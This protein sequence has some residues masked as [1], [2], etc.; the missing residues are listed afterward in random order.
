MT[1][2]DI[3]KAADFNLRELIAAEAD[4]AGP[5]EA[6]IAAKV[7]PMIPE[8]ERDSV[9]VMLLARFIAAERP[10]L[11]QILA[12]APRP[13]VR[14]QRSTK[15]AA[16][17]AHARFL[18]LTVA[19]GRSEIKWMA[20]CTYEDLCYA[21]Q[22]R[23]QKAAETIAAAEQYEVLAALV[24]EHRVARVSDLP[25]PVLQEFLRDEKAAA[26]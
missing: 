8:A 18:R 23:R 14:S 22:N 2:F 16:Y 21:A 15:V 26:A 7:W 5:D 1:D 20:D 10:R 9:G 19:V 6:D 17:Q 12:S 4:D 13:R 24:L 25:Q 11:A 3:R